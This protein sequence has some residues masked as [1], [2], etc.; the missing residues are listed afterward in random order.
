[1]TRV[2]EYLSFET[3][4]VVD[5]KGV[6]DTVRFRFDERETAD[7]FA[8][9]SEGADSLDFVRTVVRRREII[10]CLRVSFRGMEMCE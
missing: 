9:V 4:F 6:N 2:A 5:S 3:G 7:P 10:P 1:M 8:A